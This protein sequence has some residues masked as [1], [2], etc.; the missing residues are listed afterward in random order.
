M[1][2]LSALYKETIFHVYIVYHAIAM[3]VTQSQSCLNHKQKNMPKKISQ[4]LYM[5]FAK[6]RLRLI[7]SNLRMQVEVFF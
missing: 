1:R 5:P 3:T 6:K 4:F 2:D 7:I